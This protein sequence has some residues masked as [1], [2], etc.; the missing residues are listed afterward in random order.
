MNLKLLSF[1][2]CTVVISLLPISRLRSF[3]WLNNL[4]LVPIQFDPR[5]NTFII[6]FAFVSAIFFKL[7]KLPSF[8]W[9]LNSWIPLKGLLLGAPPPVVVFELGAGE[10]MGTTF[11]SLLNEKMS[12]SLSS[13]GAQ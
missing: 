6:L 8:H 5:P 9:L 10:L 2:W 11:L 4:V 3:H 12:S 13:S 1:V 7:L